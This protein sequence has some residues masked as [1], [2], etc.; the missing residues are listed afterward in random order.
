MC[1]C[2]T[3]DWGL[4]IGD[5]LLRP[6]TCNALFSS[7]IMPPGGMNTD[8]KTGTLQERRRDSLG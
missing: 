7:T 2:G 4:G 8:W 1:K 3:G 6:T 5:W